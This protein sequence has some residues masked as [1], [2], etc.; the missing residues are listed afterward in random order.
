MGE[1]NKKTQRIREKKKTE[2]EEEVLFAPREVQWA[3]TRRG[4]IHKHFSIVEPPPHKK[5][6]QK[7]KKSTK[8]SIIQT[9]SQFLFFPSHPFV[10]FLLHQLFEGPS[11]EPANS[12]CAREVVCG[13]CAM[14]SEYSARTSLVEKLLNWSR[15]AP[16]KSFGIHEHDTLIYSSFS[17]KTST[18]FAVSR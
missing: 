3:M 14:L 8:V 17:Q 12:L 2:D 15:Q 16:P 6:K 13:W 5:Q 10:L 4:A 1:R 9:K 18:T 7:Q 11:N